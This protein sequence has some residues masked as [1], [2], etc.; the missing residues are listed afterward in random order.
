MATTTTIFSQKPVARKTSAL[1]HHLWPKSVRHDVDTI[2]QRVKTLRRL[3]SIVSRHP[4]KL[5]STTPTHAAI[6]AV[7]C[8]PVS[9]RT[10]LSSSP[11]NLPSLG[12][13][14]RHELYAKE[15]T[16][17]SQFQTVFKGL[18]NVTRLLMRHAHNQRRARYGK[19]LLRMFI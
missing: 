2:R 18:R 15:E 19:A 16:T 5:T 13:L 17:Q 3:V 9:L 14:K 8:T 12:L 7:V 1:P 6:W 11:R 4:D 10:V